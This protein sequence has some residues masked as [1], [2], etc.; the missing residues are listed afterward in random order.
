M[1]KTQWR[2][3]SSVHVV[4]SSTS[5]WGFFVGADKTKRPSSINWSLVSELTK[6]AAKSSDKLTTFP[7][8]NR[9]T[10][11][12]GTGENL[13]L[14][15]TADPPRSWQWMKALNTC[16]EDEMI[17]R[18]GLLK[19]DTKVGTTRGMVLPEVEELDM[20]GWK[21]AHVARKVGADDDLVPG[22]RRDTRLQV[23]VAFAKPQQPPEQSD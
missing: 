16:P 15:R 11:L 2:L 5:Q 23:L 17:A 19:V 7:L 12:G 4:I 9:K 20:E 13:G 14:L 10:S 22:K 3:P 18:T 6:F 1:R 21:P 8:R